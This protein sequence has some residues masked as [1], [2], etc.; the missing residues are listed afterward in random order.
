[1]AATWLEERLYDAA[2]T[3]VVASE[4]ARENL[5]SRAAC[6]PSKLVLIPNASDCDLFRPDNV[7][8]ELPRTARA[9]GQVRGAS[10]PARWAAPTGS[11]QLVDAAA[12]L[13]RRGPTT[14]WRWSPSAT[15][16]SAP[17]SRPASRELGLDNLLF[18][19]PVP[20]HEPGRHRRRRRRHA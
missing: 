3:V 18:L 1:M 12:E 6:R 14:T 15:A 19:P 20:K 8:A 4:A 16:A 13:K 9:R 10:T 2:D 7:D 17:R 11:A 5:L